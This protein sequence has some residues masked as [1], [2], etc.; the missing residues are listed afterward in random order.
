MKNDVISMLKEYHNSVNHCLTVKQN[1]HERIKDNEKKLAHEIDKVHE[2]FTKIVEM[3]TKS[4][5][6]A[7]DELTS[8]MSHRNSQIN[9]KYS[10][11][12]QQIEKLQDG[13]NFLNNFNNQISKVSYEEFSVIK[14]QNHDELIEA[15]IQ[16]ENCIKAYK[17][18]E[19]IFQENMN[20][21]ESLGNVL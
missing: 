17:Q 11:I 4:K 21:P 15:G 7:I 2:H 9:E 14:K 16:V 8:L 18:P 1:L 10:G 6:V 19:P 20:F 12:L 13:W 5:Q 3:L